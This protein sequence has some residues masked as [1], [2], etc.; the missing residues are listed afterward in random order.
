MRKRIPITSTKVHHASARSKMTQHVLT[1]PY[2]VKYQKT[3]P[4]TEMSARQSHVKLCDTL[5]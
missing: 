1:M 3:G 5:K 4:I 2:S